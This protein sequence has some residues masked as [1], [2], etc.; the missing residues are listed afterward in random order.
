MLQK[1]I[2]CCMLYGE[3]ELLHSQCW[4]WLDSQQPAPEL[5]S[6]SI[7]GPQSC[8]RKWTS[9]SRWRVSTGTKRLKKNWGGYQT[10]LSNFLF[11]NFQRQLTGATMRKIINPH[12]RLH[13]LLSSLLKFPPSPNLTSLETKLLVHESLRD[14]FKSDKPQNLQT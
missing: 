7:P 9:H 2:R 11:M 4:E 10:Y 1:N 12:N 3:R 14:T 6:D 8:R 13:C 5:V